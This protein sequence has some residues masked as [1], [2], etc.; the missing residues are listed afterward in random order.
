MGSATVVKIQDIIEPVLESL[1]FELVDVQL[2]TEQIGL[3]LRVIIYKDSGIS[4]LVIA[5]L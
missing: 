4:V 5:A 2:R 1:G 3:V